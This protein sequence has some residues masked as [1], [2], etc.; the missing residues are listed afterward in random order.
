MK[1]IRPKGLKIYD[2]KITIG[3][4]LAALRAFRTLWGLMKR[5]SPQ[6]SLQSCSITVEFCSKYKSLQ[7][8]DEQLQKLERDL[9]SMCERCP[10]LKANEIRIPYDKHHK[11]SS[12]AKTGLEIKKIVRSPFG[13]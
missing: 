9:N 5:S 11:V 1:V 12:L 4:H 13:D 3:F 6:Q 2:I 8:R 7:W 10:G